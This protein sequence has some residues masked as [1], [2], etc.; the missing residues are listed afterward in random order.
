M[1]QEQR[2]FLIKQVEETCFE[3]VKKLKAEI[4][5]RPSLN[6]HLVAAFLDDSIQFASISE[7]REKIR[8]QVLKYG[9]GDRLVKESERYY[10]NDDDNKRTVVVEAE[11]LFVVPEAYKKELEEYN[12]VR[13]EIEKKISDLEAT[14][15]T[16]IM[17]IQI[18]SSSTM[19]KLVMQIDSMG[20]LDII[21]SQLMLQ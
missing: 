11:D 20:D 19:D 10:Q 13:E 18:G 2:K 5:K 17:K 9:A 4:P 21:N 7:L 14:K 6:N 3:Q 12:S 15:K 1:N 8:K 16:I